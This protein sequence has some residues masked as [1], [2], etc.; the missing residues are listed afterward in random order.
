MISRLR[1]VWRRQ[2]RRA[3]AL[4]VLLIVCVRIV[5]IPLMPATGPEKDRSAPFPCQHRPCGCRSAEQCWRKC[6]CFTNIQKLAWAKA[7]GVQPPEYVVA[8]A[9]KEQPVSTCGTRGCC[10][11]TTK[12]LV[13]AIK[14]A[15]STAS[16]KSQRSCCEKPRKLPNP[17][18]KTPVESQADV[19]IIALA[20]ECQGHSSF[21]NSLPWLILP[22]P[23]VPPAFLAD[24]REQLLPVSEVALSVSDRPPV[25]PPRSVS[26]VL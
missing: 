22:E 25:P 10:H 17:S 5:P 13:L 14:N 8:A 20:E 12:P 15:E 24:D 19:V 6:C 2:A 7:N 3:V 9:K 11:K 21:W 4:I 16:V 23:I 1:T 26:D 18:A